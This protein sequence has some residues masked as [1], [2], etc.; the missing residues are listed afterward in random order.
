MSGVLT[1]NVCFLKIAP[2][3]MDKKP[4]IPPEKP[5]ENI[6]QVFFRD[7]KTGCRNKIG[8]RYSVR[9]DSGQTLEHVSS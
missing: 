9:T 5:P 3:H 1:V 2:F 6:R 8:S 4:P 7:K